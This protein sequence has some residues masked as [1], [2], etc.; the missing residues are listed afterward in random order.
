MG[1]VSTT[2][3][4]YLPG[5]KGLTP[6]EAA[7]IDTRFPETKNLQS[8]VFFHGDL[9]TNY[10]VSRAPREKAVVAG[11]TGIHAQSVLHPDQIKKLNDA[12]ITFIWMALPTLVKG[13][14]FMQDAED[15][16]RA[17]LTLS[18]SPFH[19]LRDRDIPCYVATHSTGGPIML[20]LLHEDNTR[21]RLTAI[22]SGAAYVAP[23]LDVPFASRDHSLSI[24]GIRPLHYIFER[25]SQHNSE[26]TVKTLR[27]VK[28]YLA[29]TARHENF[30]SKP[31]DLSPT[32]GQI[33]EIQ[34]YSRAV[35]DSFNP[36]HAG[37]LSSVVMAGKSDRFTCYKTTQAVAKEMGADF[38]LAKGAGHDPLKDR[39]ELVNVFVE[40]VGE[41][42][43]RYEDRKNQEIV[44]W[45]QLPM[46][47]IPL[48]P[49]TEPLGHRARL[50]LQG[51]AGFLYA[52]A[53][54]L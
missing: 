4:F 29:L 12:G 38:Y 23:F 6:S 18:S 42:I 7:F 49:Y 9:H 26:S 39:P 43:Q 3:T 31:D 30:M 48:P 24:R 45:Q 10:Y 53:S 28:A 32:F 35:I 11:I 51:G 44:P 34:A 33:R 16:A 8:G 46:E 19:N 41:C 17:F 54:F 20:K 47:T 50:A 1:Q 2:S 36:E 13:Q 14:K 37:A 5:F 27:A 15:L 22:F 25:F 21:R 40:K 52:A